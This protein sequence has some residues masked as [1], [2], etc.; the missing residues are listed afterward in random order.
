MA[1]GEVLAGTI[2]AWLIWRLTGGRVHATDR[3]NASRTMLYD[4]DAMAWSPELCGLFGVPQ[5]MLPEVRPS[6]GD[7]GVADAEHLGVS[8]PIV[9]VAGDQT[10]ASFSL[11]F[12]QHSH[13]QLIL[14][15]IAKA[16]AFLLRKLRQ[17]NIL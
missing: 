6:S 16:F 12:F 5:D 11:C 10:P 9:G 13:G 4:I 3:T 7:F 15:K 17:A 14:S 8:L 2:D 1:A